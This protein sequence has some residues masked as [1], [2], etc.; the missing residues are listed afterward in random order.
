[1]S[2]T[3]DPQLPYLERLLGG[4]LG[5][6]ET[7]DFLYLTRTEG[8]PGFW[9]L[10]AFRVPG[11]GRAVVGALH[12]L[13]QTDDPLA[14]ARRSLGHFLTSPNQP[15]SA[16][17]ASYPADVLD[18]RIPREGESLP[19]LLGALKRGERTASLYL[20]KD[21]VEAAVDFRS[22]NPSLQRSGP[23]SGSTQRVL[24]RT[25]AGHVI[26]AT[27]TNFAV[28]LR[29]PGS[30]LAL[31]RGHQLLPDSVWSPLPT[32]V[33][34]RRFL[35]AFTDPPDDDDAPLPPPFSPATAAGGHLLDARLGTGAA[36]SV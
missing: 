8:K 28:S 33:V 35:I 24:F 23:K 21:R 4:A 27:A 7:S 14:F 32:V 34:H 9:E 25:S 30:F 26:R 13:S 6:E 18:L 31:T 17:A 10:V 22:E 15:V 19:D 2:P 20:P 12:F 1:M 29:R 36:P 3:D 16:G 5:R 11:L